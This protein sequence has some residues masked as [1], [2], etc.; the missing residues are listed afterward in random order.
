MGV[1]SLPRELFVAPDGALGMAPA[2][3]M[4]SLR[5]G[6]I[7][8]VGDDGG[9]VRLEPGRG[10]DAFEVEAT[11]AGDGP[12]LFDLLDEHGDL[13]VQVA[14]GQSRIEMSRSVLLPLP[15]GR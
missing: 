6:V 8:R 4:A 3:E 13:V 7:R 9:T 12:L 10:L 1:M 2:A 15:L 5:A 14:V 11:C